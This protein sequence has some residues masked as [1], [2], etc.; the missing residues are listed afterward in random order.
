MHSS[1]IVRTLLAVGLLAAPASSASAQD[2]ESGDPG[3]VETETSGGQA[4]GET[5]GGGGEPAGDAGGAEAAAGA[6]LAFAQR[7]L[8]LPQG[9]LR[10]MSAPYEWNLNNSGLVL[11]P[12]SFGISINKP[13]IEDSGASATWGIG[14]AYGVMDELEVGVLLL[15]ISMSPGGFGDMAI[16]GRYAFL[17][18]D[19]VEVGGNLVL[20]F[21]TGSSLFG[22]GFGLPVSFKLTESLR[23]DTGIEL[24]IQVRNGSLIDGDIPV[25]VTYNITEAGFVGGHSGFTLVEGFDGPSWQIPVGAHG[26]YTLG[27]DPVSLDFVGQL[28][29]FITDGAEAFALIFGANAT[30]DVGPH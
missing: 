1:N 14:A 27:L 12:G 21:P 22:F 4:G 9:A 28:T 8:T 19:F 15:P 17:R 7:G 29:F 16:Y 25:S 5:T 20:S 26:G 6:E 24:E 2:W 18:T 11:R 3:A 23:L 13:F 30:F 10:V